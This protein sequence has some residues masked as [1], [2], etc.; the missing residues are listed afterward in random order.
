[1]PLPLWTDKVALRCKVRLQLRDLEP[2]AG[3]PWVA[4]AKG[5]AHEDPEHPALDED[6][7]GRGPEVAQG[8]GL[9][10]RGARVADERRV[11]GLDQ[12]PAH[13]LD[14]VRPRQPERTQNRDSGSRQKL[15]DFFS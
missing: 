14:E 10:M 2:G 4:G 11:R 15:L 8:R 9:E 7:G 13:A 12:H 1:M 5:V 3:E 6:P